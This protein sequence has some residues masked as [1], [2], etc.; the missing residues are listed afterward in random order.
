MVV[1]KREW[2]GGLLL[3]APVFGERRNGHTVYQN[4]AN[5]EHI[6]EFE[7]LSS[8]FSYTTHVVIPH[9]LLP[10][11]QKSCSS[12]VYVWLKSLESARE[13]ARSRGNKNVAMDVQN[14]KEGQGKEWESKKDSES[15][16]DT[17]IT[18]I[19]ICYIL[20]MIDISEWQ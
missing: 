16:V 13:E 17:S 8:I 19:D 15:G 3:Q 6:F 5:G 12:E 20:Y 10:I 18:V 11:Q 7:A 14:Y 4:K 2:E 9:R 1:T